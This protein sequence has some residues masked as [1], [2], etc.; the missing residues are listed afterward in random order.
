MTKIGVTNAARKVSP[1]G[2]GEG[3]GVEPLI[4]KYGNWVGICGRS[5]KVGSYCRVFGKFTVD[6]N[7]DLSKK[8]KK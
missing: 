7:Q 3:P 5:P 8:K 1:G 4:G 6:N 2:L